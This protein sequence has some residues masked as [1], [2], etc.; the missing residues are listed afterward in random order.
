MS[1]RA[2]EEYRR[3]VQ[4]RYRHATRAAKGQILVLQ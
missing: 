2:K 4:G 3:A 1:L